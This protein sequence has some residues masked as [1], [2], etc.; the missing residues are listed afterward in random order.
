MAEPRS[1]H[2]VDPPLYRQDD[3]ELDDANHLESLKGY[4]EDGSIPGAGEYD[5]LR[6]RGMQT[7]GPPGSDDPVEAAPGP[8]VDAE[9]EGVDP[10][11]IIIECADQDASVEVDDWDGENEVDVLVAWRTEATDEGNLAVTQ[12]IDALGLEEAA[13]IYRRRR[14]QLGGPG[15]RSPLAAEP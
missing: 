3:A 15:G 4:R 6:E 14:E 7:V 1:S 8:V 13:A 9:Q 5:R 2:Q 11:S 12:A 10:R